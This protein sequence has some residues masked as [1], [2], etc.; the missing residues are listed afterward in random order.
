MVRLKSRVNEDVSLSAGAGVHRILRRHG[1]NRFRGPRRAPSRPAGSGN[2][3]LVSLRLRLD[4]LHPIDEIGPEDLV[5]L[6]AVDRVKR[7]EVAQ[8][9]V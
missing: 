9:I 2:A 7:P 8:P 1:V 4:H 5:F 3:A 6:T